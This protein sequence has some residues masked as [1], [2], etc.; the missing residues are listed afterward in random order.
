MEFWLVDVKS[1]V[2]VGGNYVAF[3]YI[4]TYQNEDVAIAEAEFLSLN[5]DVLEISVHKWILG[6]D[7][8]QEH[9]ETGNHKEDIPFHFQNVNHREMKGKHN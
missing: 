1:T 7:G 9:S 5:E 2:N 4:N 8:K 6:K 3:D